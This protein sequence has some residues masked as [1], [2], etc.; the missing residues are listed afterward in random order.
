MQEIMNERHPTGSISRQ[1]SE[2][3]DFMLTGVNLETMN[4]DG[5][6]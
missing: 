3:P 2:T 6:L 1:I 4:P 5:I